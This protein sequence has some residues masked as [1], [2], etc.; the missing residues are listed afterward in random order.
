[1]CVCDGA[2]AFQR[3]YPKFHLVR[4]YNVQIIEVKFEFQY[5]GIVFKAMAETLKRGRF[6]LVSKH[7]CVRKGLFRFYDV[8]A[9]KNLLVTFN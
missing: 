8:S 1:M 9:K 3:F 5:C 7:S 4:K 2:I 6:V